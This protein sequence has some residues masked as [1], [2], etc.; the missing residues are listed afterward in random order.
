MQPQSG[1]RAVHG[2]RVLCIMHLVG[3]PRKASVPLNA[4]PQ[5]ASGNN[6]RASHPSPLPASSLGHCAC[7]CR[8]LPDERG[9]A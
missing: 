1:G 5:W 4:M 7:C 2:M 6:R 9:W 3:H 8:C